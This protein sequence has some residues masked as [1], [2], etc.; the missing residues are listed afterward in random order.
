[1]SLKPYSFGKMVKSIQTINGMELI[2]VVVIIA[3]LV[4]IMFPIFGH[5]HQENTPPRDKATGNYPSV[6]LYSRPVTPIP[7]APP[8]CKR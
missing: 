8:H 2:L 3:T 4:A 7:A 1:M 6:Q 5:S